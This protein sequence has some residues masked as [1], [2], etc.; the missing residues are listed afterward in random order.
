MQVF[1]TFNRSIFFMKFWKSLV[2][3]YLS[4]FTLLL[5]FGSINPKILDVKYVWSLLSIGILIPYICFLIIERKR[6]NSNSLLRFE[7]WTVH[8]D[9]LMF[10]G[11]LAPFLPFFIFTILITMHLDFFIILTLLSLIT[12]IYGSI[13][14]LIAMLLSIIFPGI[15]D[16]NRVIILLRDSSFY[17]AS[18]TLVLAFLL[19]FAFY[20]YISSSTF[21]LM[22]VAIITLL[23]NMN[24]DKGFGMII[25]AFSFLFF[26]IAFAISNLLPKPLPSFSLNFANNYGLVFFLLF[27][28]A[29]LFMALFI[30][31][32]DEYHRILLKN[33]NGKDI[34]PA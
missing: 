10:L 29:F 30:A 34:K 8:F 7:N 26:L 12:A 9:W 23:M 21:L 24:K 1:I 17:L 11:L 16:F 3:E 18:L 27:G 13:V 31:I 2:L 5:M 28:S 20:K 14:F 15:R 32:L 22:I 6:L 25:S 4:Q 19:T 33:K